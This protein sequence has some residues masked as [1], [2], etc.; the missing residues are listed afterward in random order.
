MR[1]IGYAALGT[2]F[3]FAMTTLGA[4]TVFLLGQNNKSRSQETMLGFAGGVLTGLME[5]LPLEQCV[6]RACAIGAIQCT[7][8][9]DN[10]GLPTPDQLK[11]FISSHKRVQL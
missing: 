8:V 3:T 5:G 1:A 7:F 10:E 4:A 9:G 2:L 6:E 11:S